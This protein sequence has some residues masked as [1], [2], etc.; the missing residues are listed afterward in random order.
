MPFLV[1]FGQAANPPYA[2]PNVR[3]GHPTRCACSSRWKAV[4]VWIDTL[5]YVNHLAIPNYA[6]FTGYW[7]FAAGGGNAFE[8]H[9]ISD[10]MMSFRTAKAAGLE[11]L[12]LSSAQNLE[13]AMGDA[14][15]SGGT[16]DVAA[17]LRDHALDIAAVELFQQSF[18]RARQREV[19]PEDGGDEIRTRHRGPPPTRGGAS[20]GRRARAESSRSPSARCRAISL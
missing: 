4:N 15:R 1:V 16:P 5:Q 2:I 11:L 13:I 6:P 19:E 17:V 20:V 7:G 3:D 8:A 18:T 10:A 14:G 12:G 9:Y